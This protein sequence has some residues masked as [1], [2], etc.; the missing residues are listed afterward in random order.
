MEKIAFLFTGQGAQYVGMG[1]NFY[2][3]YQIAKQTFEEANDVLG[4]DL[5]KM[6][7]EGPLGQLS[8]TENTQP[9]M[10]AVSI[11]IYRV[12]MEEI[13][14]VPQFSAG[15]S[16]GE[17]SALVSA[18]AIRFADALK[19]VRERGKYAQD[20]VSKDIG[21]MTI[22]D[23]MDRS[24]IEAECKKVSREGSEVWINCYNSPMQYAIAGYKEQVEQ[25]ETA[26]LEKDA[27]ITPL[28]GGAPYHTP[29]MEA[30]SNQLA[31]EL[32]KYTIYQFKW[33]VI[34]NIAGKP[35]RDPE[36]LNHI[37]LKQFTSPVQ[38]QETLGYLKKHGVTAVIEMGPQNILTK[39]VSANV[40][41]IKAFCYGQKD[42]R[43]ELLEFLST[44]IKSR[45]DIPT[46]VTR[47]MAAAVATPNTNFDKDEYQAGVIEQYRKLQQLQEQLE[48]AGADPNAEQMKEAFEILKIIFKTKKVTLK[49]QI[50]WFYQIM[51]ETST[52]YV[53]H[54][55]KMPTEV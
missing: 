42:G 30:A 25:V 12:Y 5:A 1:K 23:G 22:I 37:L 33:P 14:I 40:P 9:A 2:D 3:G 4:F 26:L 17:Y 49:E 50:E 45:K 19:L 46:V 41:E 13:G 54:D 43:Q 10:L 48:Q 11:A 55:F 16:L 39:L 44:D 31:A 27:Q 47:S 28:I 29:L 38:W 51:D 52:H 34:T 53:L 35:N 8:Q 36:K 6:C 21:A 7:F 18:G 24:T 20:I 32:D 15:H